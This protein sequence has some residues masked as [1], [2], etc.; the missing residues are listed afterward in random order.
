MKDKTI[1]ARLIYRKI[2]GRLSAVEEER[3]ETWLKEGREHREYYE[4]CL[5][6]T[7]KIRK[8]MLLLR[9]GNGLW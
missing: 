9:I 3:F 7:P 6:Y 4:R 5:L 2:E 8:L 1:P